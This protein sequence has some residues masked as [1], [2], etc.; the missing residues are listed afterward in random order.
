MLNV[1]GYC[2]LRQPSPIKR[3][4]RLMPHSFMS[5]TA[6]R[7]KEGGERSLVEEHLAKKNLR[8]FPAASAWYLI[9]IAHD[10]LLLL[11]YDRCHLQL[12]ERAGNPWLPV[13]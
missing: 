13:D 8:T 11:F 3:F 10:F 7:A 12:L 9:T 6:F 2:I 5:F 4:S 1:L